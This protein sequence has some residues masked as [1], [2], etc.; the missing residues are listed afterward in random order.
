MS[1]SN[2]GK[3]PTDA[4]RDAHHID[5]EKAVEVED[6][7]VLGQGAPREHTTSYPVESTRR[8]QNF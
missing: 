6:T 3:I 5:T 2:V 8:S 1:Q 7:A 4:N